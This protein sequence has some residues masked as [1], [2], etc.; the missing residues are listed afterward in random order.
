MISTPTILSRRQIT[1]IRKMMAHALPL[2]VGDADCLYNT[3]PAWIL[4]I[5]WKHYCEIRGL[6]KELAL[7]DFSYL[8]FFVELSSQ[9]KFGVKIYTHYFSFMIDLPYKSAESSQ[10]HLVL[11]E[12]LFGKVSYI[13]FFLKND[14]RSSPCP[15]G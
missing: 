11:L 9:N 3:T 8:A 5:I 12:F 1:C 4:S 7:F 10:S 2:W 6:K 13:Y 14:F 15:F